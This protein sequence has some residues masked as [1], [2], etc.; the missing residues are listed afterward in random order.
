ME[1]WYVEGVKTNKE[2]YTKGRSSLRVE[3]LDS[4]IEIHDA[5]AQKLFSASLIADVLPRLWEQNPSEGRTR[6]HE[7]RALTQG[8]MDEMQSLLEELRY[9]TNGLPVT[10]EGRDAR[11]GS[12][13]AEQ[14]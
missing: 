12:A 8:A 13:S 4:A 1:E 6:L 14:D 9:S 7:L 2:S 5:I 10:M 11:G 3:S